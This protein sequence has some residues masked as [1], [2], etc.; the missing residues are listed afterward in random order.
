[1]GFLSIKL[2]VY[3]LGGLV[4][5]GGSLWLYKT[6]QNHFISV[7]NLHTQISNE[8]E[9]AMRA[10]VSLGALEQTVQL[11]AAHSKELTKIRAASQAKIDTIR[12]TTDK[13]KE[14]L[15]DR[16]RLKRVTIAKPGLVEKLANR[17]TK[18]VF[19]DLEAIYN[20]N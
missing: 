6:V 15:Q 4:L 7:D 9:R 5:A 17:A 12:A 3:A 14:V 19:N 13:Q 1:M 18:R 11:R 16:D 2:I 20:S 10:E 8:R